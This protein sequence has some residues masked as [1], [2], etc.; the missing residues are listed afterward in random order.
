MD[1]LQALVLGI[2][3]GVTEF[4]PVSS[5][6][7]L[8]LAQRAMGIGET[9]SNTAFAII[10]QFGAILAVVGLFWSRV[11]SVFRGL[12]GRDPAGFRL[13]LH[14]VLA[15]VPAGLVGLLFGRII[16]ASLFNLWVVAAAWLVGGAVIVWVSR[17]REG[18]DAGAGATI[19]QLTTRTALVIGLVQVVAM[20]PGVSRSLAT[21]LG[22][23]AVGLSLT[24]AVEFSFL[25]G[26]VTLFAATG[27]E[28]L[29]TGSAMLTN[30]GG[31]SVAIGLIAA[32][33]SAALAI[34]WMVAY[35]TR[36]SL[37]GFGWYRMLLAMVT[38]ALLAGQVLEA[39]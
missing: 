24:A 22:G 30:L 27:K 35:L 11:R 13:G 37:A 12:A 19:E 23:L 3:E 28:A 5:T 6:G 36:R 7:H 10:V 1:W 32:F 29:S 9:E 17:R 15:F 4:L 38:L 26:V 14:L 33:L 16:K 31:A 25:L 20:W 21:I 2:V 39:T 18:V 8:I 34:R